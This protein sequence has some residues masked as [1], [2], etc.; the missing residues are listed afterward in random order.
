MT[1][2]KAL[3]MRDTKECQGKKEISIVSPDLPWDK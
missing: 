3:F 2:K 1:A